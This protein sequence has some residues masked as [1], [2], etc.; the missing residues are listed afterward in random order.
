VKIH[1]SSS[2]F[3][4]VLGLFVMFLVGGLSKY[5][6]KNGFHIIS[7]CGVGQN[8]KAVGQSQ[9]YSVNGNNKCNRFLLQ[10]VHDFVSRDAESVSS[11]LQTL[12]LY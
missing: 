4:F 6:R 3:L 7:F 9:E 5:D 8:V 12:G 10:F 11:S 1:V 2:P